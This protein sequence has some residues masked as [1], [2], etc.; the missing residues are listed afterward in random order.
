MT[1]VM[2]PRGMVLRLLHQAQ[3]G[4]GA[5]LILQR[6]GGGF[7]IRAMPATAMEPE[8]REGE[9]VFAFYRTAAQTEPQPHDLSRWSDFT[10]LFL[11]VSVGTKGVLQLRGWR[12]DAGN[13]VPVDLSLAE[14]DTPQNSDVSR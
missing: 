5:G 3:L 12:T 6:Q 2:L 11:S 7:G 8:L 9:T 13:P 4:D 1:A 10:S 14:E